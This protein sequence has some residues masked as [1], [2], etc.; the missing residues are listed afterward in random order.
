MT[1]QSQFSLIDIVLPVYQNVYTDK[2][3]GYLGLPSI[4][5]LFINDYENIWLYNPYGEAS[6]QYKTTDQNRIIADVNSNKNYLRPVIC[7]TND[8]NILSGEGTK[9]NPY[10]VE[11]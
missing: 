11:E 10:I 2:T 5:E 3:S 1:L 6:L 9:N 8:M 7:I 4:G